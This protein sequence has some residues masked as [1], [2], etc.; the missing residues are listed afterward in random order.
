M[1]MKHVTSFSASASAGLTVSSVRV[2][3]GR[4]TACA[5]RAGMHRTMS[6]H[7]FNAFTRRVDGTAPNVAGAVSDDF[8]RG[9]LL[10]NERSLYVLPRSP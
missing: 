3:S 2:E 10:R 5:A 9:R 7:R 8:T 4:R 1:G 6:A